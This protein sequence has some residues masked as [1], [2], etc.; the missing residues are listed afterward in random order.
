MDKNFI[1][2]FVIILICII[3]FSVYFYNKDAKSK[4]ESFTPWDFDNKQENKPRFVNYLDNTLQQPNYSNE[5]I[6]QYNF[7]RL[8]KNIEKV[9]KEKITLNNKSNYNFY[10]QSTTDDKLRMD[11]DMISKYVILLLN[12]DNYYNFNKTNFGDVEVW[13]D[14]DGNEEL[15]YEL[16]LWDK[17]NYF[18]LKILVNIIKFIEEKEINKY[19]IKEKDYIFPDFNIGLPFKDQIIPLP[20]DVI[21]TANMDTDISSIKPNVPSKI[22]Y[23][24]LNQIEVQ[25][26]TLVVD[27]HKNKYPFNRLDV[28]ENGFSGITDMSLEYVNIKG[29]KHTPYLENGRQYNK[30]PTLNEEP[31]F[32]GQYPSK[33]PPRH[34]D[35]DGVYYYG[36]KGKQEIAY[37][38]D[39]EKPYTDKRLCDVYEPGTRW[40][41]DKEPLQAQFWAGNYTINSTCGENYWLFNNTGNPNGTFYGG[42][43]K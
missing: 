30:W 22:K 18:E 40:S 7:K 12:N 17:K 13:I 31:K 38:N 36:K 8:F 27:Y 37:A 10:T 2:Y 33:A 43:K 15:K 32:K 19:G 39:D 5:N 16:F 3:L 4:H 26:S 41:N 28:D 42:G 24:Y 34:W 1:I 11:L 29:G 21:I 20:I 25:N 9:N 6:T 35:D 14:K 23:L